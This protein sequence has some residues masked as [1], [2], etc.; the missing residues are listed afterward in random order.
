M[1]SIILI[2]LVILLINLIIINFRK[3]SFLW[4]INLMIIILKDFCNV[5]KF[6]NDKFTNLDN[7][8]NW[9]HVDD[10]DKFYN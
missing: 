9:D 3:I 6:Y 2:N 8:K 7:F 5:N 1:N 4:L 10:L